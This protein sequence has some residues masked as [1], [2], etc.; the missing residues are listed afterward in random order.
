MLNMGGLSKK[1]PRTFWTFLIGGLA[2]SGFPIITAGFWSK[3]EI[4]ADA[5][6]NGH[7]GVFIVLAVAAFLTAFY[8]ARQ[9]TLTFGGSARTD[10]A[11]HAHETPNTMT[12]PLMILAVFA[13][14]F[15]WLG[16]PETFPILGPMVNNNWFHDFVGH[17]LPEFMHLETLPFHIE[18]LLTSLVVALGGL[19][20]GWF[21]YRDLKQGQEDPLKVLLGPVYVVLQNKYYVDELYDFVFVRPAR[22]FS[23]EFSYMFLDRELIDGLLHSVARVMFWLGGIFRNYF[24]LPVINRFMGD[25]SAKLTGWF[26]AQMAKLQSGRIQGYMVWSL[27]IAFV[28]LF[29]FLVNLQ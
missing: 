17:G 27:V 6:H 18:P 7:M 16:I 24:D 11:A 2:L 5:W 10:E 29:Y 28:T 19:G 21:V 25:G 8:T 1:M 26:G 14:G 20:L 3:D 22:W 4:L 12:I 9:I 13:I 23:Q 15:G